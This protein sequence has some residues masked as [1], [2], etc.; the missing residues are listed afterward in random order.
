M[1]KHP[2]DDRILGAKLK[3]RYPDIA[4][5]LVS[6]PILF[7]LDLLPRIKE[8]IE[9]DIRVSEKGEFE[10]KELI[11]AVILKLYDPYHLEG[12]KKMKRGLP[13]A[14]SELFPHSS[15]SLISHLSR[16]VNNLISIYRT[17]E[18]DV[19]YFVGLISDKVNE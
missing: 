2:I 7:D 5:S 11:V 12:Y 6:E 10:R 3:D 8:I 14:I 13:K 9:S 16:K 15:K 4:K 19:N 18:Q 17:F 1:K